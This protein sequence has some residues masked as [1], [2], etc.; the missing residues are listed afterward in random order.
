MSDD[1]RGREV[2]VPERLYK[3][4]TVFSTLFAVVSVV[5]GFVSLDTATDAGRAAP[6]EVSVPLAVLGVAL[7][8][9]GGFVYAFSSRFRARGMAKDKDSGDESTDNG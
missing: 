3:A 1:E 9:V 4:V 2:V 8:A 6:S 5:L 7:I